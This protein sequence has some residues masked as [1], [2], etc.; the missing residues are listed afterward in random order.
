[1]FLRI[2]LNKFIPLFKPYE[3]M[4]L[5]TLAKELSIEARKL[6]YEQISK[7][8][9]IQRH[10][11]NKEV[12]MYCISKGKPSRDQSI[13][14]PLDNDE[15]NLAEIQF[16]VPQLKAAYRSNIFLVKGSIFSIEFNKSPLKINNHKLEIQKI[17][18]FHDPMIKKTNEIK[19][20][21]K[22]NEIDIW[23]SEWVKDFK[24]IS[25]FQPLDTKII[26]EKLSQINAMLPDDYLRIIS[27]T[28][29]LMTS[30]FSINGLC[31]I[32]KIIFNECNYYFLATIGSRGILGVI[33]GS[34]NCELYYLDFEQD[35]SVVKLSNSITVAIEKMVKDR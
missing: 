27:Q 13:I 6:F 3:K 11:K 9:Y 14:F 18:I 20:E 28:E 22:I 23:L 15:T 34:E 30:D 12:N 35:G 26:E 7:I 32:T 1:M 24:D 31:E 8:N 16:Y 17:S 29:G 10:A 4:I 33:E 25:L 21:R 5:D 2:I 19:I